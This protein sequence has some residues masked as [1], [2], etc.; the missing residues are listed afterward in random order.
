MKLGRALPRP[1]RRWAALAL[2]TPVVMGIALLLALLSDAAL[3][4]LPAELVEPNETSIRVEDAHGNLLREVRT[5]SGALARWLPLAEVPQFFRDA[6]LCV[7]DRHFYHHPGVDPLAVLRAL[8]Q[9]LSHGHVISGASTL[10]MQLARNIAPHPR[11]LLAK[12]GEMALAL[13]IEFSLSKDQILEQYLNRIDFGPN[14][15]GLAAA[16]NSYFGVPPDHLSPAQLALLAGLPQSPSAYA[17]RANP[18]RALARRKR[19]LARLQSSG[20]ITSAEVEALDS[21]PLEL[22]QSRSVFGAP[23]FVSALVIG[24]LA[25]AQ[26]ALKA[27]LDKGAS[28]IRTTLDPE[29]QRASEVAISL[30]LEKLYGHDVTAAAALL[31]ETETG[32]VRAY[33]GSPNF[34]AKRSHG[35]VDGVNS[36][37]QP[38]STLKPFVYAAAMAELG[39]TASTVLADLELHVPTTQ[40]DYAPRNYDDKWHGPVR[41]REALANSINI[42]AVRTALALGPDTLL[43]HLHTLGFDSLDQEPAYYGPALAL[44]DGEVT[45]LELVRAYAAI[46]RGGQRVSLNFATEVELAPSAGRAEL[47]RLRPTPSTDLLLRPADAAVITDILKD[48]VARATTFGRLSAL[49]FDYDVAV[50]TGTSKGYR[51]NWVVGFSDHYT[52]G[53]WVGNFDGHPMLNVGGAAGAAPIFHA[54]LQAASA[55]R[56]PGSLPL[57]DARPEQAQMLGLERVE[58]CPLSGMLRSDSCPHGLFEW[59]PKQDK[60][61]TCDWHQ[62]VLIDQSNGLIAGPGCASTQVERRRLESYPEEFS[63]WA[64]SSS[65]PLIPERDS[66]NCP[67]EGNTDEQSAEAPS[68][69]RPVDGARYVLDPERR[70]ELQQIEIEVR[71][72]HGARDALQLEIDGRAPLALDPTLSYR[73]QLQTGA[74]TFVA[75]SR[76]GRRS[77]PITVTVRDP[78]GG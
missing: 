61:L 21:E 2:V 50:K 27:A 23:H 12:F 52:L 28:R 25:N 70:P 47:V 56:L 1:T 34:Y 31:V 46:A 37:R 45:L 38:G 75:L 69:V 13:R 17:L 72:G 71:A 24:S 53:V 44:G 77:S 3:T 49:E 60:P 59:V 4:P 36:K 73:W 32:A 7:E 14:L 62:S 10:T 74:H 42:P 78:G 63:A 8:G 54:I 30:S 26:P 18:Q 40:G 16:S 41:L 43:R 64:R 33:V 65:R 67:R 51:D 22:A 55:A 58:V 35:Q 15:R 5:R 48:P 19:V 39:Y 6:L 11:T 57:S 20:A 9:W 76:T 29:L 66:P 68:I